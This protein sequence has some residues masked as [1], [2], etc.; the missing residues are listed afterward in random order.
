VKLQQMRC[1]CE[2]IDRGF[3]VSKAAAALHTS[4]PGVSRQIQLLEEELRV[5]L[6]ERRTTRITG[7]TDAGRALLPAMRRMLSEAD[8]LRRQAHELAS[9]GA[10]GSSYPLRIRTRATRCSRC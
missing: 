7:M 9:S 6:L 8:N 1:L 2:V 5:A 4:Q 3:N 10:H